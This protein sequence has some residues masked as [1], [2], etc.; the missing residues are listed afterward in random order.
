MGT[1]YHQWK[2]EHKIDLRFRLKLSAEEID[3]RKKN[4][5]ESRRYMGYESDNG[6]KSISRD[7]IDIQ[8]F[9][10]KFPKPIPEKFLG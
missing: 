9:F 6:A 3:K 10:N 1:F 7:P 8:D 2:Q 4:I 5:D